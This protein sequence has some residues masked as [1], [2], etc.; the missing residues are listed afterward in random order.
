[1]EVG[2]HIDDLRLRHSKP[3]ARANA[4]EVDA[5]EGEDEIRFLERGDRLG[6]QRVGGRGAGVLRMIGREAAADLEIG[7]HL[8]VERLRE[9]DA[10]VPAVEAARDAADQHHRM[11]RRL[12]QRGGFF[13]QVGAADG[14]AG[15]M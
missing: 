2:A 8:G 5:V 3:N 6:D 14:A 13:N 11:L 7:D 10:L 12:E 1:M 4:V 15:G 9:R